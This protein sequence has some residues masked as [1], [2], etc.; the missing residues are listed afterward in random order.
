[1]AAYLPLFLANLDCK[2]KKNSKD[3]AV[4]QAFF[5]KTLNPLAGLKS[6]KQKF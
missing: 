6:Q 2:I 4:I 1:M 5:K 3:I